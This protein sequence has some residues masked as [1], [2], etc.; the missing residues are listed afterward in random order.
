C[1]S[2]KRS[3][4]VLRRRV[5]GT[6]SSRAALWR[7]P[8]GWAGALAGLEARASSAPS[9][10]PLVTRPSLP[11]PATEAVERPLSAAMRWADGMAGASD[12]AAAGAGAEAAAGAGAA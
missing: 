8:D 9:M 5:I 4:T 11:V 12:L 6:I 1:D 2:F 3:A 7:G 10:S